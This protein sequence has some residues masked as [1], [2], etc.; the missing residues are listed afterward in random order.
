MAIHVPR[1]AGLLATACACGLAAAQEKKDGKEV[2]AITI[3]KDKKTVTVACKIA[4]RK[5]PNLSEIYPIEVIATLPAPKGQKAHETVVTF[6]A[7]PSEI[8]KAVESLG[9]KPGKPA[10]GEDAKPEGPEVQI[11]L[12]LAGPGGVA[13][14]LPIE[15]LLVDRKTGKQM[16]KIK[17]RFTGSVM[18]QPDPDKPE[19]VF[20]ADLSGTLIAIFPVTDE[21]VFQ[22]DLTMKDEPLIK[23]ETNAKVLPKEGTDVRL[24][25]Q[26]P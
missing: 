18:K 7:K 26:V 16:P 22:T 19:K 21:T 15:R 23:L 6:D 5:L 8:H 4:P 12:E 3:D 10:K 2:P 17:F 25:I 9:L 13:R 14:R 24:V 1:L 11:S 20:G